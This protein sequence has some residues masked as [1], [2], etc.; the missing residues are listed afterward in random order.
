VFEHW[1]SASEATTIASGIEDAAS[2][3]AFVAGSF[4]VAWR[5]G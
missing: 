2:A 3:L 5:I 4:V 1:V